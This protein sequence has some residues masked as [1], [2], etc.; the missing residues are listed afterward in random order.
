MQ[1]PHQKYKAEYEK[2]RYRRRMAE[3]FEILGGKCAKCGSVERLELDHID[4]L[5][6]ESTLAKMWSFSW[7]NILAELSKCQLLCHKCHRRKSILERG[8]QVATG[9]HGTVS[10][11]RH[12]GPPKCDACKRARNIAMIDWRARRKAAGFKRTK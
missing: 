7:E 1:T 5:S 12:C 2:A 11:Y 8:H 6:K 9:I 10:S 3:M 4:P